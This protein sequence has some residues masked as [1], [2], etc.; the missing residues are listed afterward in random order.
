[1][2]A[3]EARKLMDRAKTLESRNFKAFKAAVLDAVKT[4]ATLGQ[5]DLNFADEQWTELEYEVLAEVLKN[6]GYTA[7]AYGGQ[8]IFVAW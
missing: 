2:T 5:A 1:M 4:A 6:D 7:A 8:S 3:A